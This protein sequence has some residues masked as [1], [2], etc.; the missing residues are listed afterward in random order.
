MLPSWAG[1][2]LSGPHWQ[3]V[4]PGRGVPSGELPGAVVVNREG[5]ISIPNSLPNPSDDD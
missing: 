3:R 5:R 1:E 4:V 2:Q